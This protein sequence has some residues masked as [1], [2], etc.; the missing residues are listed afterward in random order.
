MQLRRLEL[1]GIGS[2]AGREVIDFDALGA[3][4][5]F[6]V[7]GPTGAGKSTIIDA[8]VFGLFGT[9]AGGKESSTERLRSTHVAP[10]TTSYADVIFTIEAGTFRVRRTPSFTKPGNSSPT[11]ATA[12]LWKLS[13]TAV[14]LGDIDGGTPIATKARDVGVYISNLLGL[15]AEQF[16]QTIV[17]PQGKFAEFLRLESQ[18]RTRLLTQIFDTRV[19]G[20]VT[21]W[22]TD[23][24][25]AARGAIA[26]AHETFVRAVSNTAT[27]LELPPAEGGSLIGA[28]QGVDL[29]AEGET[30]IVTLEQALAAA[31]ERASDALAR[32]EE[33]EGVFE[34]AREHEN[35]QRTLASRIER[36]KE[37]RVRA[38]QLGE[39]EDAITA[40][41]ARLAAHRAATP[42]LPYVHALAR[43]RQESRDC[44][45]ACAAAQA[46]LVA[47]FAKF[48]ASTGRVDGPVTDITPA[49][50]E[51]GRR[52]VTELSEASGRLAELERTEH[53]VE[54]KQQE[55]TRAAAQIV[56]LHS[57]V[58]KLRD[59]AAAAAT[60]REAM[61]KELDTARAIASGEPAAAQRARSATE[62]LEVLER[63]AASERA[64]VEASAA[65][66]EALTRVR[67]AES[68]AREITDAWVQ[69]TAGELAGQLRENEPCPVCGSC[70]HPA[71]AS[72]ETVR[73]TAA[74]VKA[75]Q[76]VASAAR[77]KY[78]TCLA[79][80]EKIKAQL[81]E[82]RA[83]AGDAT[84]EVASAELAAARTDLSAAQQAALRV[85]DVEKR[86]AQLA[87]QASSRE[88]SLEQLRTDVTQL[89]AENTSRTRDISAQLARLSAEY[90]GFASIA[91]RR[92]ALDALREAQ[93]AWNTAASGM[94]TAREDEQTR[95]EELTAALAGTEFADAESVNAAVLNDAEEAHLQDS[96]TAF[97]EE[98]RDVQSKLAEPEL[99]E[100]PENA[101]A[102]VTEAEEASALARHAAQEARAHATRA[103]NQARSG[104]ERLHTTQRDLQ[105]WRAVREHSGA[106]VRLASLATAGPESVTKVPLESFVLQHRFEQVVDVANEQLADI[107]L[108]RFELIRT[109]EKEKGSHQSKTGLGLAVIDHAGPEPVQRSVRTLSGGE[110]FYVSISLALA[111][112]EVVRAENGGIH[113]DTLLIDEGFGSL[114]DGALDQVMGVLHGLGKNGRT[115][116]VVSHVSEMKQMISERISVIPGDDGT[117]HIRV[118]A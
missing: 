12:K 111:L 74:Q 36:R 105:A 86:I 19:F 77:E 39:R 98:C 102:D 95:S 22:L 37:L 62:L 75:S 44:A 57:S 21:Q 118:T 26:S 64:E 9:V 52:A 92:T 2:F 84:V 104:R 50:V 89:E 108:G 72:P 8:V 43:A 71:P 55:A 3:S 56:E 28:A 70:T 80:V 1:Q 58:E 101:R 6:L 93:D 40:D 11:A 99:A 112:A 47:T 85:T 106:V 35:A 81:T 53:E 103:E 66:A 82:Q 107:S 5:L 90:A 10:S 13:E 76:E 16:L 25:R 91:E 78:S 42:L 34:R 59:E 20:S 69:S 29:P 27:A 31:A 49:G 60:E 18:E 83:A 94:L 109:D 97:A 117:S 73:A 100:L 32:A 4:G 113:L 45:G 24:A 63:V 114:S 17:L 38:G 30:V 7:E 41:R 48:G 54:R 67:E 65:L 79:D 96:I 23:H 46:R 87:E 110:T 115:V 88:T 33:A 51:S 68:T 61:E 116:G 14:D 15:N